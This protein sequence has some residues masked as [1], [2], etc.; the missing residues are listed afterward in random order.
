MF[1]GAV[2]GGGFGE[3]AGVAGGGG[4]EDEL[5]FGRGFDVCG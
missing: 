2:A 1:E 4:G 5:E 3:E